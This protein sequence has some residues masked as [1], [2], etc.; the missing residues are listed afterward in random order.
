V[1]KPAPVERP[2]HD[3]IR[4]RWSPRAISDRP[5]PKELLATLFEAARWAPSCYN[6]QP[7]RY[8]L[9][10]SED[11]EAHQRLAGLLAEGNAWARAAPALVLSVARATFTR[12][13]KP[14]LHAFHDVGAATE[15]LAIEASNQGLV[16]HAMGG[17]KREEARDVLEIPPEWE[18]VAMI[19]I[20]YV[21]DPEAL[22]EP[23]REAEKAPRTRKPM[24]EVV[25][26][27]RFGEPFKW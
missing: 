5:V 16:V 18:P 20:G 8:L 26:G 25:D 10:T 21:G 17:F 6:E 11:K 2:V 22:P 14:N 9:A 13:E 23:L 1:E 19:A 4:R 27:A 3:L 7:W 15:N 24:A 12:N